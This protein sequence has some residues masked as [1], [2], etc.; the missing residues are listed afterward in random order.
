MPA[1]FIHIVVCDAKSPTIYTNLRVAKL[2][3]G[4]SVVYCSGC[5]VPVAIMDK[6]ATDYLVYKAEG[7]FQFA[8]D[9]SENEYYGFESYYKHAPIDLQDAGR[10][11]KQHECQE[12]PELRGL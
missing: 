8:L 12:L 4:E 6:P 10:L 9:D 1:P 3:R 7:N 2:K 5:G 11:A